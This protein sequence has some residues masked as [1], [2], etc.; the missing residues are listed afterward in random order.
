METFIYPGILRY[1]RV[2]D[3]TGEK[4]T[5][6]KV[7]EETK[8]K[9]DE[10]K[11]F[12]GGTYDKAIRYLIEF[13]EAKKNEKPV[14]DAEA[15]DRAAWYMLKLSFSVQ[16]LKEIVERGGNK[17]EIDR[18]VYRIRQ[19]CK[20]I[21]DRLGVKCDIVLEAVQE[22]LENRDVESKTYLNAA[23]KEVFK[24][25]LARFLGFEVKY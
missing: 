8:Q 20:Q 23:V 9:L 4:V 13:Y 11:A 10:I 3:M 17:A 16:A 14:V 24:R 18:Q 19:I 6:V 21:Y 2:S 15:L 5:T 25:I 22:Y 12:V 1:T 7:S